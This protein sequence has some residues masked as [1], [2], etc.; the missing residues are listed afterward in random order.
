MRSSTR[1]VLRSL[2]LLS[3]TDRTFQARVVDLYQTLK[4]S[5]GRVLGST[6]VALGYETGCQFG[7]CGVGNWA[8]DTLRRVAGTQI[9]LI[10]GGSFR[11]GFPLGS[12]TLGDYLVAMPFGANLMSTFKLQG[13]Y[14]LDAL[15]SGITLALPNLT[16]AD[17]TGRFP[18]VSAGLPPLFYLSTFVSVLFDLT[19][20]NQVSGLRFTWNQGEPVGLR[21]VD[22]FVEATPGNWQPL[23]VNA[24]YNMTC[25][26]YVRKGGDGYTAI[27]ANSFE[28]ND[29]GASWDK[30]FLD[31]LATN[32]PV[33]A[34]LDGRSNKTS[35]ARRNCLAIDGTTCSNQG[36]CS[37]GQCVCNAG[38]SGMF[39]VAFLARAPVYPYLQFKVSLASSPKAPRAAV[40]T[41]SPSF[42]GRSCR[43]FSLWCSSW[44]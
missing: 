33:T 12:V 2:Q 24:V 8:A 22:V 17:G 19:L 44:W 32:S 18:Q 9:A 30:I 41:R 14:I 28:I 11:G 36:A 10:N 37:G 1:F 27:A 26:D 35:L 38:F 13:K 21:V 23:D 25:F 20:T 42:S 3:V 40:R 6:S 5:S 34:T 31:E 43:A 7:E 15:E 29:F 4:N 39:P 16:L